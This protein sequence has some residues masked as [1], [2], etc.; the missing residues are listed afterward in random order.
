[1]SPDGSQKKRNAAAGAA[2]LGL[3]TALCALMQAY[4]E[5]LKVPAPVGYVAVAIVALAGLLALANAQG[6][7][8]IGRWLAV[9]LLSCMVVPSA[10]IALGPGRRTCS[11]AVGAVFGVVSDG[12]C[13]GAFG[14]GALL[15]CVLVWIAL[16]DA[17]RRGGGRG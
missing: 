9:A 3:A 2:L 6:R 10:W 4:P 8:D 7:R 16:K 13:R 17:L 11:A 15:G 1:M 14:I 12:T 5:R